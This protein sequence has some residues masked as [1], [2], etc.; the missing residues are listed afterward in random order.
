LSEHYDEGSQT[1]FDC[2]DTYARFHDTETKII[3]IKR[4]Y[5]LS[6]WLHWRPNTYEFFIQVLGRSSC[7]YYI[8]AADS[9]DAL[10]W[11]MDITEYDDVELPLTGHMSRAKY[12]IRRTDPAL[13][14]R[15]QG[16]QRLGDPLAP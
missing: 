7:D 9:E 6:S 13:P 4:S 16:G 12:G 8:R 15:W 2:R 3:G 1:A 5:Y 14:K 10:Q 11:F